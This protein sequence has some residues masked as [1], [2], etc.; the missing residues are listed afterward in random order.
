MD[1]PLR[2]RRH[3]VFGGGYHSTPRPPRTLAHSALEAWPGRVRYYVSSMLF[4][5]TPRPHGSLRSTPSSSSFHGHFAYKFYGKVL[6]QLLNN[7]IE[8]EIALLLNPSSDTSV[9]FRPV[10]PPLQR[11]NTAPLTRD[12]RLQIQTLRTL[13]WS[14]DKIAK[15]LRSLGINCTTDQVQY[16]SKHRVTPQK[17]RCGP[18]ALLNTPARRRVTDFITSSRRTRKMP[19]IQVSVCY[20]VAVSA[21]LMATFRSAKSFIFSFLNSLCEGLCRKKGYSDD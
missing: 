13:N 8:M 7:D 16:A 17:H 21:V 19:F 6:S 15:H 12:Q 2:R 20:S 1:F 14:Y 3:I 18:K 9:S 4:P 10:T 5:S 11:H